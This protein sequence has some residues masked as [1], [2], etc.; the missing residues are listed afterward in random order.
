MLWDVALAHG[1][2]TSWMA[3]T[4]RFS[5]RRSESAKLRTAA[6]ARRQTALARNAVERA[7]AK[8]RSGNASGARHD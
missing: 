2:T 3:S 6:A 8:S 5:L 4:F 1:N 7:N